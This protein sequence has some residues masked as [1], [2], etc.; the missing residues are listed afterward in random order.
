MGSMDRLPIQVHRQDSHTG[1]LGLC[2][3]WVSAQ[4]GAVVA[5]IAFDAER[6]K[7]LVAIDARHLFEV[8]LTRLGLR[9][10]AWLRGYVY[11]FIECFV[12]TL[13]R[14][15]VQGALQDKA[16]PPVGDDE[17]EAVSLA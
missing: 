8:N 1:G 6:D 15:V 5:S 12:P 10:G 16:A 13:T 9:K 2:E 7:D 11:D 3:S 14:D 17:R 4:P